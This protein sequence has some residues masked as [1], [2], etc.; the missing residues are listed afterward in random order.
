MPFCH[1]I[2]N[3]AAATA[4]AP[5]SCI[6]EKAAK[7]IARIL[8]KTI[9]K[10]PKIEYNTFC[11]FMQPATRGV[12]RSTQ[13]GRRGAPAKGVGRLKPARE[14]KSPLLRQQKENFCLPK[15]LFLFIQAAGLAYHHDA[16]VDIISPTGCIS[17]RASVYSPAA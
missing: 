1:S 8:K 17:S 4:T 16:V 13:V 2:K 11:E 3:A 6:F 12:W 15:V 14:F 7:K 5:R 10:R 9:D